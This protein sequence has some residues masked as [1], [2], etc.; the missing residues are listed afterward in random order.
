[1]IRSTP[2]PSPEAL[3]TPLPHTLPHAE[4]G[5][6]EEA[7]AVARLID[8]AGTPA[9]GGSTVNTSVV[10]QMQ[11]EVAQ[12]LSDLTR[13]P[14]TMPTSVTPGAA[15]A[16][17]VIETQSAAASTPSA[18]GSAAAAPA[19]SAAQVKDKKKKKIAITE[20]DSLPADSFPLPATAATNTT[21]T[22]TAAAAAPSVSLPPTPVVSTA[23][24]AA[25]QSAGKDK[26]KKIAI[27]EV[28]SL[29]PASDAKPAP[30]SHTPPAS[31]T[32]N[33]PSASEPLTATTPTTPPLVPQVDMPDH[34]LAVRAKADAA[35]KSGQY[36]EAVELYTK[37]LDALPLEDSHWHSRAVLL[38]NRASVLAKA[39]DARAAV[40]DL[41]EA[42]AVC[43]ALG[44]FD[45][46]ALT[47][48]STAVKRKSLTLT[49][50]KRASGHET[51]EKGTR[52][53]DDYE[54]ALRLEPDHSHALAGLERARKLAKSLGQGVGSDG[55]AADREYDAM[56]ALGNDFVKAGQYARAVPCYM[57]CVALKPEDTVARNNR[58]QCY[59]RLSNYDAAVVDT[60]EILAQD[61]NNVKALYRRG[62]A[63]TELGRDAEATRDLSHLITLDPSN[64]DA[65]NAL[66]LLRSKASAPRGIPS[67]T[68]T[69]TTTKATTSPSAAKPTVVAAVANTSASGKPAA[70]STSAAVKPAPGPSVQQLRNKVVIEE[71]SSEDAPATTS[72]VTA[73]AARAQPALRQEARSA[74][75]AAAASAKTAGTAAAA[76]APAAVSASVPSGPPQSTTEF[77]K[78][79]KLLEKDLPAV[80][81]YVQTAGPDALPK[82]FANQLEAGHISLVAQAVLMHASPEEA[83]KCL[84]GLQKC[85]RFGMGAM[86][87]D[88]KDIRAIASLCS[89]A[90]DKTHSRRAQDVLKQFAEDLA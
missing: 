22:T 55:K 35:M 56:K 40:T 78:N 6:T 74:P 24:P 87:L 60:T 23:S 80:A 29:A 9:P 2:I 90:G 25:S 8:G 69:T 10:A 27:A 30:S 82:L 3:F 85:Q 66:N 58:A 17:T 7:E 72:A 31:S 4:L 33:A 84:Q 13:L 39:G 32:H 46:S 11:P 71:L 83:A 77:L 70:A 62:L 34:V 42:L 5:R 19:S 81:R 88:T 21:T 89:V 43:G 50:L 14:A 38:D 49:L 37:A 63:Y 48:P 47:H 86:C 41:T 73:S 51:L 36:S 64:A 52:A 1:M 16:P 61:P 65:A 18:I 28:E 75:A 79:L 59:L 54:A 26:K 15:P 53:V 67:A 76:A 20:V 57:R 44:H 12:L 45:P 68:T